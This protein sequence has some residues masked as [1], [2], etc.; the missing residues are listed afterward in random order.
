[1]TVNCCGV[2]MHLDKC[3]R[4]VQRAARACCAFAMNFPNPAAV[5]H[6]V[7]LVMGGL[8]DSLC[9]ECSNFTGMNFGRHHHGVRFSWEVSVSCTE[10]CNVLHAVLTT[11]CRHCLQQHVQETFLQD[12]EFCKR[13]Q[14]CLLVGCCYSH[15]RMQ[16]SGLAASEDASS[17]AY[18]YMYIRTAY[19]LAKQFA[20]LRPIQVA[21]Q[22]AGRLKS[23]TS[24]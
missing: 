11:V 9:D 24:F 3:L 1:M 4:A 15:C 17:D 2:L 23:L 10:E 19:A 16:P 7:H 14:N 22:N 12:K 21:N 5:A 8:Q 13:K 20:C 18:A 6:L